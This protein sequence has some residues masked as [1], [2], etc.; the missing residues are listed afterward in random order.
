MKISEVNEFEIENI[1]K[2]VN[3][4][5]LDVFYF[6]DSLGALTNK[7]IVQ[8]IKQFKKFCNISLDVTSMTILD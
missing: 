6:A 4:Y 2:L 1:S 5:P 7:D 8:K 3:N